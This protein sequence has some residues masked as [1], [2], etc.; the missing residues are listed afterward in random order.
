MPD[1]ETGRCRLSLVTPFGGD[2]AAMSGLVAAALAGGDVA[3]LIIAGDPADPKAL[4][5]LA[6]ALVPIAARRGVATLIHNDTRVAGHVQADGVHVDGGPVLLAEAVAALRPRK[7]VGAGGVR[8]RH[9]A[10][11]AGEADPDYVFFGRLDGDTGAAIFPKALELATWW[12]SLFLIPAMVMGGSTVASVQQAAEAGVEF[13]ALGGAV[14]AAPDPAAAVAE[15]NAIL[16]AA[17]EP[18]R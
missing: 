8:S 13:V 3:S 11:E 16:A 15:A 17:A 14:L 6:K 10:M 18:V 1:A 12:S 4:E 9:E 7:I 2:P 5:R